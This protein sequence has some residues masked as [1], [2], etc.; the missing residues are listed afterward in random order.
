MAWR[1]IKAPYENIDID[2]LAAVNT[3]AATRGWLESSLDTLR[4]NA[5]TESVIF[6]AH[7]PFPQLVPLEIRQVLIFC[8]IS[9]SCFQSD[10]LFVASR[11]NT[12]VFHLTW[13]A[14]GWAPGSLSH[15]KAFILKEGGGIHSDTREEGCLI[16]V[17][18]WRLNGC[19]ISRVMKFCGKFILLSGSDSHSESTD[20]FSTWIPF[21]GKDITFLGSARACQSRNSI[22]I[23][24]VRGQFAFETMTMA[25][26]YV[27]ECQGC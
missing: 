21:C 20:G 23:Y 16:C 17:I 22:W 12:G 27:Q 6:P 4:F 9:L 14:L 11:V 18:Y 2:V 5:A 1:S 24:R 13:R 7:F 8:G 25:W 3:A 26:V 19:G 15:L 10:N